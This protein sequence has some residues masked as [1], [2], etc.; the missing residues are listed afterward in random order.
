[1]GVPQCSF[2]P[3][4]LTHL[5]LITTPHT[6]QMVW[7]QHSTLVVMLTGIVE[8]GKVRCCKYWPDLGC[9]QE[10]GKYGVT[11]LSEQTDRVIVTRQLKLK[12]RM[13]RVF[14]GDTC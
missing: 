8:E 5:T 11:N 4:H 9:K 6:H 2:P 14:Y 3:P 10:Y 13:V 1:M 7:E 12:N